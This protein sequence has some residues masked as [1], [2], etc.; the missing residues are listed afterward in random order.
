MEKKHRECS[1][2]ERICKMATINCK[3]QTVFIG[4]NREVMFGL[5]S[6]SVDLIATDP[7]YNK[8]RLFHYVSGSL[9]SKGKALCP[10]TKN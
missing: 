9:A 8:E 10:S 5:N 6:E 1:D 3:N 4:D 7:P 2:Y